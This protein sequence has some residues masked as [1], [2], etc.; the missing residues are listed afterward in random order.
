METIQI[1]K[2]I[3]ITRMPGLWNEPFYVSINDILG[4]F[5]KWAIKQSPYVAPDNLELAV[6][7]LSVHLSGQQH[8]WDN[9][10]FIEM[11]CSELMMILEGFCEQSDI[12]K[13]WNTSKLGKSDYVFVDRY[14]QPD[15]DYD[16]IDL[17]ALIRNISH[18]ICLVNHVDKRHDETR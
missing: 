12:L 2:K 14:S 3:T 9:D 6:K 8:Q 4:S 15:P 18:D 1:D 5:A 16:F 17:G 11:K 13:G 10:Q 7:S